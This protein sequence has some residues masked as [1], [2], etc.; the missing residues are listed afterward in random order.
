MI[1]KFAVIVTLLLAV[2]IFV[3]CDAYEANETYEAYEAKEVHETEKVEEIAEIIDSQPRHNFS[4]DAIL[5]VET[6]EAVHPIF[7]I[8][9]LLPEEYKQRRDE[10][11]AVTAEPLSRRDF[12]LATQR[13]ITLLRDGHMGRDLTASE[14]LEIEM[15]VQ[16]GRLFLA[17]RPHAEV[18]EIGGVPVNEVFAAIEMH[19][20]LENDA[21]RQRSYAIFSRDRA[22]LS[23]AGAYIDRG[24]VELAIYK[25]EEAGTLEAGFRRGYSRDFVGSFLDA[26]FIIRHEVIDDVFYINLRAFVQHP[27]MPYTLAAIEEAVK[28]GVWK[29][30]VDVRDNSGGF[31]DVAEDLLAA[32][33]ITPPSDG[34][35]RRT[36]EMSWW[37]VD[38]GVKY[39]YTPPNM[40]AANPNNVFISV[41][42]NADSFSASTMFGA[43][44]QDGGL[45]NII[46]QPSANAP[47]AF[48]AVPP[49]I[50]L[51]LSR[52]NI[53][54]ST[55]RFLRPDINADQNTL[56]PD[57]IVPA[58]DALEVALE[59]LQSLEVSN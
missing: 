19:Y 18:L 16:N 51:P 50:T 36:S 26:D 24:R 56:W 48:G 10:Y 2:L 35:Y 12:I 15:V 17:D 3:A 27:D 32:M 40:E 54:I 28:S 30:I 9:G 21:E 23:F 44:V 29:F 34:M 31:S 42:M 11:L 7:V 6:V 14:F 33:G 47:S 46:G 22:M 1:N 53:G 4:P 58:E 38:D 52:L 20:Y 57:I 49:P 59:F 55:T 8:S 43:W 13:Y 39:L 45:G 25:N 37:D 5:L 41:L